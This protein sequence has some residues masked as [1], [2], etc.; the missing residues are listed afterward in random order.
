MFQREEE[1]IERTFGLSVTEYISVTRVGLAQRGFSGLEV[2]LCGNTTH[3]RTRKA[4]VSAAGHLE[5]A[6]SD[7]GRVEGAPS[8]E[9]A[10]KRRD[11]EPAVLEKPDDAATIDAA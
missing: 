6:V 4:E 10:E 3:V 8:A 7:Q 11:D 5:Q 2:V 9:M 1:E